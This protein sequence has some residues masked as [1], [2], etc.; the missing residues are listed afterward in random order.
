MFAHSVVPTF[1][2]FCHSSTANLVFSPNSSTFLKPETDLQRE[3]GQSGI[4]RKKYFPHKLGHNVKNKNS[5]KTL[6]IV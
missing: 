3:Q 6:R 2:G 1:H 4:T 5:K